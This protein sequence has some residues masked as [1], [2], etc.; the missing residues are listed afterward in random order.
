M[1]KNKV[2]IGI[3]TTI[4]NIPLSLILA[5]SILIKNA[6]GATGL[7]LIFV[8][9]F[10]PIIKIIVLMLL[11]KLVSAIL[12]SISDEKISNFLFGISKSLNMLN[13][14]LLAIGFMFLI[15]ISLLMSCSNII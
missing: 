14:C 10:I 7:I 5:S 12:E 4:C 6:I 9:I 8:T 2:I 11:L 1:R 3:I 15:S 13:V